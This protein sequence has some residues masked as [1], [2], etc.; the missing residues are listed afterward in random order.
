MAET[1]PDTARD[2][3]VIGGSAGA[4]SV[5]QQILGA[6]P[7][8]F[9]A[10]VFVVIH[11]SQSQPGRLPEILARCG[12]LAAEHAIDGAAIELGHVYVAPPDHHLLVE[13]G[14]MRLSRGPKENRFRPSIDPLFRTAA[15]VYGPQVIG[16][17]L[18]GLLDDG[19]LGMMRVKQFG[20]MTIA[21]DPLTADSADMPASAIRNVACDFILKPEQIAGTLTQLV[22]Q[23]SILP[24]TKG[25]SAM[26]QSKLP[27][28]TT[29]PSETGDTADRGDNALTVGKVP[30][31][32]TGL[33]CPQCGGAVWENDEG[34]LITYRCH[35]GHAYTADSMAA[36]HESQLES[37]L[38]EA[39]RM[40]QESA[41]MHRRMEI[42][43]RESGVHEMADRYGERAAEHEA[44]TELMRGLLLHEKPPR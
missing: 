33:T 23:P 14:R 15:R 12:A 4:L 19:T 41:S 31:A 35:V 42:K 37:T 10:A 43:A 28:D 40:F 29:L 8:D 3:I 5:L 16:L 44:R 11:Q 21:Q 17:I 32:P 38:W 30:G 6:L 26:S 1:A 20:G 39:V 25:A 7:A 34:P 13:R 24:S 36:E 18:S 22:Q 2:V 27:E 9:P